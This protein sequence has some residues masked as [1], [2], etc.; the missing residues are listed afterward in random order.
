MLKEYL[1]T[2]SVA[3][4]EKLIDQDKAASEEMEKESGGFKGVP[5]VVI[6]KD[7]NSKETIIGFDKGKINSI[8]GIQE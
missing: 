5:F 2:K 7:D 4:T 3:F 6:I 1:E 8:L